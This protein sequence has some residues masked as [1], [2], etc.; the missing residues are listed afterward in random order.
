MVL[1]MQ[2]AVKHISSSPK[3]HHEP[4]TILM[5]EH[6]KHAEE[7]FLFSS[8]VCRSGRTDHFNSWSLSIL[9]KEGLPAGNLHSYSVFHELPSGTNYGYP[10]KYPINV[11]YYTFA[12]EMTKENRWLRPLM[13]LHHEF[14]VFALESSRLV[15]LGIAYM[16]HFNPRL[17]RFNS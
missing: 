10:R 4:N 12:P 11:F 13:K 6:C 5:M 17:T 14:V 16:G 15:N 2:Y 8:A 7:I 1:T 9:P 3:G